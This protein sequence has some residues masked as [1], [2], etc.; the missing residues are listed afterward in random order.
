ME[1]AMKTNKHTL[2]SAALAVAI[3]ATTV[4]AGADSNVEVAVRAAGADCQIVKRAIATD[5]LSAID[6]MRARRTL[7]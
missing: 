3:A 6:H 1:K 2:F 5:L 4:T 7:P